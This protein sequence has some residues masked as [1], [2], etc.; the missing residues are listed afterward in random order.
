MNSPHSGDAMSTLPRKV[1][2]A[3]DSSMASRQALAYA[4]NILPYGA[5]VRLVSVAENPHTLFP[6]G[7]HVGQVLDQARDELLRDA[8]EALDQARDWMAQCDVRIETDVIDLSKHGSDVVDALLDAADSW[9]ADLMVVGARQHHGLQRWVEGTVSESLTRRL[10]CPMLVVPE[11]YS[12]TDGHLPERILFAIDGSPQSM[13]A[14]QYGIRFATPNTYLRALYV[15]DRAVRLSDF[16]PIDVLEDAFV[17]EGKHALAAAEPVLAGVSARTTTALVRTGRTGDDVAH[18]IVREASSWDAQL[19]V[20]GTHG[21][22]GMARWI[23]GSVAGRVAHI[24]QTPLL[25]IHTSEA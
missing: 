2:I 14:L 22:R 19:I 24:T 1:L 20:M 11:N 9:S 17:G 5:E 10:R 18:T 6:M 4:R 12:T 25:L 21:R 23:L 3:V 8:A 7:R 13:S 15:I 16:S